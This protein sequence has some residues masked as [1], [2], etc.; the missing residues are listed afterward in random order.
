MK[1]FINLFIFQRNSTEFK[2]FKE[3][4]KLKIHFRE[5]MERNFQIASQV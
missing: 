2:L 4:R 3:K 1:L 5:E